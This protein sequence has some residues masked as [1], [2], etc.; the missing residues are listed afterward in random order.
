VGETAHESAASGSAAAAT[1]QAAPQATAPNP[2]VFVIDDD[3]VILLSCRRIL[4]GHGFDVETY[5]N[6]LTGLEHLRESRPQVLVVDLKMPEIDGFQLI[7]RARAIDGDLVIVVITGYATIGTAVDAMKAGAYD[8]LPKPFTPDELRLIVGRSSERWRLSAESK[9]LRKEKEEAERRFVTF[10]SHQL[11]TPL[12][13]VKQYLDVL[14]YS[15]TELPPTASEWLH[16]SQARLSEMLGLIQDWLTLARIEH[17][18]LSETSARTDLRL[19]IRQVVE[20]AAPQAAAASVTVSTDLPSAPLEAPGDAVA[21]S[22]LVSNLVVN[23]IKYNRRNGRV[24]VSLA[25]EG[26]QVVLRVSD[27]GIGISEEALAHIFDEFYR[28]Q[29]PE[30]RAVPGTGLGLA[31]CRR[32]A[33]E[34][35]GEI[36]VESS[37]GEGSTF[38]VRLPA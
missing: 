29:D 8:F 26:G 36:A 25:L 23:A 6:G 19:V 34:L 24:Q 14:L 32:I 20:A 31:I 21:H 38:T 15:G 18:E 9:R 22:T 13:A 17:G 28:A 35:G 30:V 7:E 1:R 33:R 11:K 3:E 12:V 37:K 4:A 5:Q 16:R 10:V 27:T 2:R